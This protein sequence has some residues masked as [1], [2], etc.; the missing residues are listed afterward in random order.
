MRILFLSQIVPYPPDAGPRVKTWHVL[1]HLADSGHQITLA[2]FVRP[3]ERKHL[4]AVREVC[5]EVLGIPLK[6]SRLSDI[7][8]LLLSYLKR[9][10]F[11]VERDNI[12]MMR[13][14]V[15]A[16]VDAGAVDIIH[17]DQFTM[18][19]FALHLD[20]RTPRVFDAHNAT[21]K[22]VER[23]TEQYPGILQIFLRQEIKRIRE[24]ERDIIQTFEH[25]LTVSSVDK[26]FLLELFPQGKEKV[27]SRITPTPI[28]V[29]CEKIQPIRRK[30]GSRSLVTLGT[31]HY[32]PN[33]DG[34]RWFMNEVFP[35]ILQKLPDV[36][37]TVIGKNPPEDFLTQAERNPASI[38]VTGYVPD[39][40]PYFEEAAMIIVPVRSGGGM[41][42]RILEAFAYG[43]PVV[44]TTAG[45]EGIDA[46]INQDVIVKDT[47][48]EFAR[49]VTHL[50]LDP[51]QQ[52][53]LAENG[54]KLAEEKYHWRK[55]LF[56]L[57]EVYEQLKTTPPA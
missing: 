14:I 31:L 28:S 24:Y 51:D 44:T 7:G 22:L 42:V 23:S 26:D 10:P 54:R 55:A 18:A 36:Q 17:A 2:T 39:L 9:V 13:H 49:A 19:Q 29:D 20:G 41:R 30:S 34:I 21:W 4:P 27:S 33:A 6:R 46:V 57:D 8:Y 37:L 56:L 12:A 45:L 25:T 3:E 16:K 40:Q 32:P 52:Q 1:R 47:P 35:L 53:N 5:S 50:L 48:G 15:K 43:L 38:K 11:L